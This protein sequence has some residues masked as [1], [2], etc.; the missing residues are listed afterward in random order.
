MKEVGW[1]G[2]VECVNDGSGVHYVEPGDGVFATVRLVVKK[3]KSSRSYL[4]REEFFYLKNKDRFDNKP[5]PDMGLAFH[6]FQAS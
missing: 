3:R 5:F 2:F 6:G 4:K 1:M